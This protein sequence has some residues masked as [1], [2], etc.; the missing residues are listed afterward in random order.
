MGSH[1][2]WSQICCLVNHSFQQLSRVTLSLSKHLCPLAESWEAEVLQ[3]RK[4]F[5]LL[6][7]SKVQVSSFPPDPF[8]MT[9]HGRETKAVLWNSNKHAFRKEWQE[10]EMQKGKTERTWW[11]CDIK[12]HGTRI[13]SGKYCLDKSKPAS[14]TKT[15][16]WMYQLISFVCLFSAEYHY[17]LHICFAGS[18]IPTWSQMSIPV[19]VSNY[20]QGWGGMRISIKINK[21][22]GEAQ[23]ALPSCNTAIHSPVWHGQVH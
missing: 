3:I 1:D 23:S 21:A 22:R 18:Y 8:Q 12:G 5:Y 2:I 17:K 10:K 6:L 15:S 19:T 16:R 11:C 4:C 14:P 7:P 13:Q 20:G 9:L